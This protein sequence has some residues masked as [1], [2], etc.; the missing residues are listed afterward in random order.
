MVVGLRLDSLF[1][2]VFS[3]KGVKKLLGRK[4]VFDDLKN[5]ESNI[6]LIMEVFKHQDYYKKNPVR[7][8]YYRYACGRDNRLKEV[9]MGKTIDLSK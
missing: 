1:V 7:Y 3:L 8:S 9:W 6:T 5:V 4:I 2:H